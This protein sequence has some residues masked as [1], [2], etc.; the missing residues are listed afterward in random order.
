MGHHKTLTIS[1]FL[2]YGEEEFHFSPM[3]SIPLETSADILNF[4][5]T[6]GVTA[7]TFLLCL[8]LVRL[9]RVLGVLEETLED[10]RDT[11]E[12]FQ[13]Y[14]WQPARLVMGIVEKVKSLFGFGKQ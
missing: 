14:L 1:L 13:N 11:V 3:F 4:I 10:I 2:A 6:I 8:V 7:V 12:I 9:F 5:L